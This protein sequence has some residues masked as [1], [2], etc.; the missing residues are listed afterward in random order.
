MT[1]NKEKTQNPEMKILDKI[2]T[3]STKILNNVDDIDKQIDEKEIINEISERL[4]I[5][6]GEATNLIQTRVIEISNDALTIANEYS[7]M[8]KF[9]KSENKEISQGDEEKIPFLSSVWNGDVYDGEEN[10]ALNL[11]LSDL[12]GTLKKCT[13]NDI[14]EEIVSGNN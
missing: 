6:K 1:D 8:E 11:L 2:R 7:D 9:L 14:V 13:L 12:K 5:E 10:E 4:K 3:V